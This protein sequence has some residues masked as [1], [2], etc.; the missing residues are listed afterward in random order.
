MSAAAACFL[1][2]FDYIK[3]MVNFKFRLEVYVQA[4]VFLRLLSNNI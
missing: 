2:C 1:F 3:F 4:V